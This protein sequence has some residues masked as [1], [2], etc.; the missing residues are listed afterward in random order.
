MKPATLLPTRWGL[1]LAVATLGLLGA[2]SYTQEVP[3][4]VTCASL[5]VTLSY[6]TDVLPILKQ[7]CYRCHNAQNYK[8]L[9][10]SA[11]NMEDF[12][13]LKSWSTPANGINGESYLI[14]NVSHSPGFKPMP[15]DG[16]GNLDACQIAVLKAWVNA[17]TPNN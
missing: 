15:Y 2:C 3:P 9:A 17:G 16:V 8:S 4:T 11:L 12:N 6:Q 10:L 14:G 7:N 1:G 13:D 5:P